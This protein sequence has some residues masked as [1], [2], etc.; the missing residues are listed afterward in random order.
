[1]KRVVVTAFGG[2]EVL[3][4]HDV[5]IPEPG[6]GDI[7]IR[8]KAAGINYADIMRRVGLYPGGPKPPY[9]AGFEVAGVVDKV[10]ERV[11]DYRP[12]DEVAAFV[13]SGFSE[14]ALADGRFIMRKPAGFSFHQAA[15]LPCQY[16]TAYHTLATLSDLRPGQTVLIQ[17]AAG[18]LGTIL[19]QVAK[20]LGARVLGTASTAEKLD[21]IRGLGCDIPINYRET[22]FR[23]VVKQA[24]N[25]AGCELV[26]ES[27]GGE[28]LDRSLECVRVRG[29]LVTLGNASRSQT[30]LNPMLLLAKNLTI[31]GFLLGAYLLD[32]PAMARALA[33]LDRWIAEGRLRIVEGKAFPLDEVAAAQMFIE[34]RQ[35]TGKV[36]LSVD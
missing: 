30:T 26:V 3:A 16:L 28:V 33:D 14:F 23:D 10:G 17:A 15:A 35:S 31:S 32:K 34:N 4:I 24:T 1:M 21:L 13:D 20:A 6:P 9:G 29:R 18:G 7:R 27:V 11:S 8:V 2:P 25:G 36:V 5:P 22:D 19:V 12:G